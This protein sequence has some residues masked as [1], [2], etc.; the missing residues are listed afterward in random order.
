MRI[1]DE[2]MG[3]VPA[4]ARPH[5]PPHERLAILA[6]RAAR[7]WSAAETARAFLVT[8]PT[9]RVVDEAARRR[10][11]GRA[12]AARRARESLPRLR[13]GRRAGAPSRLPAPRQGA[14][15]AGACPRGPLALG[16]DRRA[17]A[18]QAAGRAAAS[19]AAH[20]SRAPAAL[21]APAS[22]GLCGSS[23]ITSRTAL[24]FRSSSCA[25]RR[26]R[27]RPRASAPRAKGRVRASVETRGRCGVLR[28][29]APRRG[30]TKRADRGRFLR[31]ERGAEPV[32]RRLPPPRSCG[33]AGC[34]ARIRDLRSSGRAPVNRKG[35]KQMGHSCTPPRRSPTL[36]FRL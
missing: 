34:H 33:R 23:S 5:Y 15:R 30:A 35:R 13:D 25:A 28:I 8:H 36:P 7:G 2:R 32:Q 11:R 6:V 18:A 29:V 26:E 19:G 24:I 22:S 31:P 4:A 12:R 3:L 17:S 9:I 27:A 1:E 10:G 21:E 14:N 20:E 16:V